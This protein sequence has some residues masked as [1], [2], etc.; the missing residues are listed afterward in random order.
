MADLWQ[1]QDQRFLQDVINL[2]ALRAY[3]AGYL[4]NPALRQYATLQPSTFFNAPF[5]QM[6]DIV[7]DY[8][9]KCTT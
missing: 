1:T 2:Y 6:T 9:I 7:G 5:T 8:A 4:L 3:D